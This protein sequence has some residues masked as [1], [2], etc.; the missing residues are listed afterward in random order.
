MKQQSSATT[1]TKNKVREVIDFSGKVICVGINVHQK[2]YQVAKEEH[3]DS[4][5]TKLAQ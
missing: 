2:D 1:E 5:N 3:R 4:V